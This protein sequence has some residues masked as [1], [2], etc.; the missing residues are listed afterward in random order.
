MSAT[1]HFN[2]DAIC[3]MR[4]TLHD[5]GNPY[6]TEQITQLKTDAFDA[7]RPWI[8]ADEIAYLEF[9][10]YMNTAAE[11]E[12]LAACAENEDLWG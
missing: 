8:T 9:E 3:A 1:K 10:N 6:S 11:S 2:W 4:P 5:D 12:L 7:D